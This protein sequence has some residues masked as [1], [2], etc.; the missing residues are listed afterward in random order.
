MYE[1]KVVEAKNAKDA[2]TQ[3]NK[4][5]KEGWR[6][7]SNT[8]GRTSKPNLSLPL[9]EKRNNYCEVL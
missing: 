6:V 3:M 7:I 2:E 9:K 8:F 4:Y 5:A 1:Y